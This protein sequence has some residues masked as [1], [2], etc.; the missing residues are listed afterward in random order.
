MGRAGRRGS[1]WFSF[2]LPVEPDR[3]L[4]LVVTYYSGE[5]RRA[6]ASFDI[7]VDGHRVSHQVVENSDPERFFDVEY[8]ID[9]TLIEGKKKVTIRF[10]AAEGNSIASVFGIR[11]IRRN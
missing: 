10:E 8:V 9:S 5:R 4:A 2:D 1:S 11:M 3:R 6:P 7:L